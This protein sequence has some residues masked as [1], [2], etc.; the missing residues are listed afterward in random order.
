MAD[1]RGQVLV[2]SFLFTRCPLPDFCP[3]LSTRLS[4]LPAALAGPA[5]AS[6]A[7]NAASV[8]R[9]LIALPLMYVSSPVVPLCGGVSRDSR[10]AV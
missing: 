7:T 10:L 1:Y 6:A 2:I 5:T 3:R 8:A 9:P 4:E